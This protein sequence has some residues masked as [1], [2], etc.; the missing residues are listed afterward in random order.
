MKKCPYCA[1]DIQDA[2]I[3]CRY[4]GRD[5]PVEGKAISLSKVE[6]NKRV[7]QKD[8][9]IVIAGLSLLFFC[10]IL[11]FSVASDSPDTPTPTPISQ[12]GEDGGGGS[13]TP[14]PKITVQAQSL[15]GSVVIITYTPTATPVVTRTS[16]PTLTRTRVPTWTP[17]PE[18]TPLR[19]STKPPSTSTRAVI[20]PAPTQQANNNCSAA[21]PSVCI[22][23]APPD[24]NCP[25][26]P[27]RNFTVLPPDPHGFDRNNDGVGCEN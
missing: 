13:E 3:V 8:K 23:P 4:C 20:A 19:I 2:A 6:Q 26:I 21:Y 27:Y 5:L 12:T 16:I 1:E 11:G 15:G 17:N 7:A 9:I 22:P 25:D 14:T 10:C 24:L 18:I